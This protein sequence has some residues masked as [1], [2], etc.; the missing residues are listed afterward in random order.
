MR[1]QIDRRSP[2]PRNETEESLSAL[3]NRLVSECDRA[4]GSLPK[5]AHD[6]EW[7]SACE[8]GAPD[9]QDDIAWLPAKRAVCGSFDGVEA[10][11]EV[12][13]HPDIKAYYGSF[14]SDSFGVRANEGDVTL[15]QIW[16]DADFD[17]LCENILGH[18]LA[19]RHAKIPLTVFIACTDEGEFMLSVDNETG[20]V[21]L[22]NPGEAPVRVIEASLPKFLQR[23]QPVV[24]R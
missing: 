9:A 13:L 10:A 14:W 4:L 1:M 16:N 3:L 12:E 24:T 19:K 22:E 11:L 5:R 23:L 7:P 18:A 6:A 15:I 21:V 8:R 2:M 17:R 20:E